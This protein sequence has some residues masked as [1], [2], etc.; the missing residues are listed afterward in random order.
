[1]FAPG[2]KKEEILVTNLV[3]NEG[4]NK[5]QHWIG[6][7]KQCHTSIDIIAINLSQLTSKSFI[8]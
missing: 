4:S 6:Q 3:V 1:M 5:F 8:L 2:I 7:Q